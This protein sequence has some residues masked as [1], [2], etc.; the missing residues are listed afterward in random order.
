[1]LTEHGDRWI[2]KNEVTHLVHETTRDR[3]VEKILS[4]LGD[5]RELHRIKEVLRLGNAAGSRRRLDAL[6]Q[7]TRIIC[8]GD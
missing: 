5:L 6:Q 2:R 1:M 7:N 8:G 4:A 3:L